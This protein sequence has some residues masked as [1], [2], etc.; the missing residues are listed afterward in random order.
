MQLIHKFILS[1]DE[2]NAL[3]TIAKVDCTC[4]GCDCDIVSCPLQTIGHHCISVLASNIL[5]KEGIEL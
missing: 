2:I 1:E 3:K 5:K 4:V